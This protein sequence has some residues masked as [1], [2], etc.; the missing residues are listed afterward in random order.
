MIFAE[1]DDTKGVYK[2]AELLMYAVEVT[3]NPSFPLFC[4]HPFTS[5]VQIPKLIKGSPQFDKMYDLTKKEDF[6]EWAQS[7]LNILKNQN[8]KGIFC[9][10]DK[11]YR[12]AFLKYSKEYLT[13][14]TFSELFGEAW[15]IS[16]NPNGD[17]NVNLKELVV[18]YKNAD[19]RYLMS[20]EDFAVWESLPDTITV[21]R[22]VGVGRKPNGLSWTQNKEKAEWFAHR[23][24]RNGKVGYIQKAVISKSE[25]FAYFN[26]RGEEEIVVNTQSIKDKII[27]L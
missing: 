20:K 7:V 1:K 27:K 8:I 18:W 10:V 12:L 17:V 14:E 23:F 6:R 22:G 3:P 24:D 11:P 13:R 9:Q 5:S 15:V 4:S 21:Y 16:E 19:K 25:A 2:I 26:S